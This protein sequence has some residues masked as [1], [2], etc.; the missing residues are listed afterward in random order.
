M[1]LPPIW[2]GIGIGP[3]KPFGILIE[4][5]GEGY[6]RLP[7]LPIVPKIAGIESHWVTGLP[8]V[9]RQAVVG[10]RSPPCGG[11]SVSVFR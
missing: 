6:G 11:P 5:W 3:N 4:V 7:E 1:K 2:D 8:I 10:V 9:E